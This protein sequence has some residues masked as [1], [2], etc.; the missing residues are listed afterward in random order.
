MP[1]SLAA[2]SAKAHSDQEMGW[3]A[4]YDHELQR[5]CDLLRDLVPHPGHLVA[6]AP[7]FLD[8]DSRLLAQATYDQRHLPSG[9]LDLAR[10]AVL[11]DALRRPA[12]PT[13]I[14]F[15]T[16]VRPARTSAAAGRWT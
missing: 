4:R 16:C 14:S 8:A 12:A 10:L 6:L 15:P 11:S 5:Q 3:D 13:L 7:R 2:V 9:H 1:L